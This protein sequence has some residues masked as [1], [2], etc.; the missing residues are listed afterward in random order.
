M[1]LTLKIIKSTSFP[2]LYK[3]FLLNE[4][5]TSNDYIK[6]LEL[7][8]IFI[9]SE[10]VC[11]KRLGYRIIVIYSNRTNDYAP[12]YEI[13][14]NKGLYPI[15]KFIESRHFE[16]NEKTFFTEINSAFLELYKSTFA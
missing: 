2:Q 9:N 5:L 7:A 6:M 15:A 13:S 1:S 12:L 14:I 10:D 4:E 16:N 3:R 11:V 8:I